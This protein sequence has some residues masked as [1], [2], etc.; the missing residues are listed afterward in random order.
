MRTPLRY[1]SE[2]ILHELFEEIN[3][4]LGDKV[5]DQGRDP[6]KSEELKAISDEAPPLSPYQ[7]PMLVE[8]DSEEE[9]SIHNESRY[10][11]H[12]HPQDQDRS[13]EEDRD[14]HSLSNDMPS[15]ALSPTRSCS[16]SPE[17][18]TNEPRS[19]SQTCGHCKQEMPV[20]GLTVETGAGRPLV[21]ASCSSSI[22]PTKSTS[23]KLTGIANKVK[24]TL[25]PPASKQSSER[26]RHSL[27]SGLSI[28]PR[29]RSFTF[30]R[31]N[32]SEAA[33]EPQLASRPEPMRHYSQPVQHP[34]YHGYESYDFQDHHSQQ[35][36][37]E[38]Y[39]GE[40][41]HTEDSIVIES[42]EIY[43]ADPC[44][45]VEEDHYQRAEP[46]P[47]MGPSLTSPIYRLK[48]LMDN[49]SVQ[50]T[51]DE[52][53]VED[54]FVYEDEHPEPVPEQDDYRLPTEIFQEPEST[55]KGEQ[56]NMGFLTP[57]RR[58]GEQHIPLRMEDSRQLR[59]LTTTVLRQERICP[60]G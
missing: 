12:L 60:L 33:A 58:R 20:H 44:Y 46:Y 2:E 42:P 40:A 11:H 28:L 19:P 53:P 7:R 51:Q 45:S 18:P 34:P 41:Y 15:P 36:E 9:N 49:D 30:D 31:G 5:P 47:S 22:K 38:E 37:A 16:E 24:N 54:D 17:T 3:D 52:E 23:S 6:E 27:V 35:Y 10:Q 8:S 55:F 4:Y 48:E 56:S 50:N 32:K 26:R 43:Q 13:P 25:S 1:R 57:S 21:C 59:V 39:N 29:M 14:D